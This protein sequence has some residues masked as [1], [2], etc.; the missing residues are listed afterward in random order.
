MRIGAGMPIK[1]SDKPHIGMVL[2]A[3]KKPRDLYCKRF[4]HSD[5]FA[6]LCARES[7]M[8]DFGSSKVLWP[9]AMSPCCLSTLIGRTS[10]LRALNRN[11][12]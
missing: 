7:V 12:R 1:D 4:L 5:E 8:L 9:F 2:F 6:L 11:A 3:P 10:Y